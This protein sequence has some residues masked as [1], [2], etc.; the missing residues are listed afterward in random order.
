MTEVLR[1]IEPMNRR[2]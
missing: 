2:K 1:S